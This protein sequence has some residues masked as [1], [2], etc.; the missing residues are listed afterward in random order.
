M[1]TT[2][3]NTCY[4][5]QHKTGIIFRFWK[6]CLDCIGLDTY[7]SNFHSTLE[8]AEEYLKKEIQ[9][10]TPPERLDKVIEKYQVLKIKK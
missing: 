9:R 1:C 8:E 6:N 4:V 5:V 7:L 2:K 10:A 3:G